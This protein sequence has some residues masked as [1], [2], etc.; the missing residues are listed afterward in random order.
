M[1]T[2]KKE[3]RTIVRNTRALHRALLK[4]IR[5]DAV[6][7]DIAFHLAEIRSE[8]DELRD[9]IDSSINSEQISASQLENI[10]YILGVH[11]HYHIKLLR[12]SLRTKSVTEQIGEQF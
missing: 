8:I 4:L 10:S 6:S 7:E 3:T 11:W 1:G 5:D 9:I 12:K 2:M